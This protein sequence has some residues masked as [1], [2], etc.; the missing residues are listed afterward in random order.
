M[1]TLINNTIALHD[2]LMELQGL[3]NSGST[4]TLVISPTM[5][6]EIYYTNLDHYYFMYE[7]NISELLY[8]VYWIKLAVMHSPREFNHDED[9]HSGALVIHFDRDCK[10]YFD[11]R[12]RVLDYATK[13]MAFTDNCKL[14]F[15]K[16][17]PISICC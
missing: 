4:I 10:T 16:R 9:E 13:I 6:F 2:V 11:S 8:E 3:V 1:D 5:T 12:T 14:L 17:E 15:S 7:Y